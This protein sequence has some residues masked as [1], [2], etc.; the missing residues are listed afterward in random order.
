MEQALL[1]D[2]SGALNIQGHVMSYWLGQASRKVA[3]WVSPPSV[4]RGRRDYYLQQ[5]Q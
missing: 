4:L 1:V 2:R 3:R 5:S